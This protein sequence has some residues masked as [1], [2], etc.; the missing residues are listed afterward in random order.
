MIKRQAYINLQFK[1]QKSLLETIEECRKLEMLTQ[2]T[3][4]VIYYL[5]PANN[6]MDNLRMV[7]ASV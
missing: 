2:T 7:D 3:Y 6:R 5:I 1:I 4:A